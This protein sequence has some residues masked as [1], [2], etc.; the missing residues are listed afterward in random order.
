MA[1]LAVSATSP[2]QLPTSGHQ[3]PFSI[4]QAPEHTDPQA[5]LGCRLETLLDILLSK[6]AHRPSSRNSELPLFP[7]AFPQTSRSCSS[8]AK[9]PLTVSDP[10]WQTD[11]GCLCEPPLSIHESNQGCKALTVEIWIS[12]TP[13]C[14]PTGTLVTQL[15]CKGHSHCTA[16]ANSPWVTL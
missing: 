5:A 13:G 9:A 16:L 7:T 4:A 6:R 3:S 2:S 10:H 1:P 11:P 14:L 12:L 15:Q 8:S